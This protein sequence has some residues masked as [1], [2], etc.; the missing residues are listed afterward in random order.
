MIFH[1]SDLSAWT[2]CPAEFGYRLAGLPDKS[3]SAAAYGS[4]MHYAL[5]TYERERVMNI[6]AGM[7]LKDAVLEA[8]RKAIET[9]VFYWHPA[10][11]EA[12]CPPVPPDG[13]LPRQNFSELRQ[14]GLDA[15]KSYV[16][17]MRY[18]E[19]EVLASEY[20]FL[21]DIEGTSDLLTG[22]PH[23]LAG[24]IDRLAA[25]FY[26]RNLTL[27]VDDFKTGKEYRFLRHNLQFTAYCYATT[28]PEFW[29]GFEERAEKLRK[30][31]ESAARRGTW[32]NMRTFKLQDAGFRAAKDYERL[33]LAV[34]QIAMSIQNDI[35]PLS[36]SGEAC[37]Y[38]SYRDI[39]GSI[40]LA[41][42]DDGD[43]RKK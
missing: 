38:C 37:T 26:S 13:W 12:I 43:P 32:I 18:D 40:G 15:I 6:R 29:D 4:V 33:K 24:S 31:F 8:Y 14:R 22:K 10:H 42:E 1:Q 41:D 28:R 39:C 20:E 2:R 30:R 17:L 23:Q 19:H 25:R 36:I 11:I 16:D 21:V 35:F 5:A 7:G 9:F 3:N 27:C 34:S